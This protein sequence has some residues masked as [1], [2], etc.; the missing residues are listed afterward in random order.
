MTL[1]LRLRKIENKMGILGAN[2]IGCILRFI[3]P[4]DDTNNG[5]PAIAHILTG[6][7]AGKQINRTKNETANQFQ[8]QINVSLEERPGTQET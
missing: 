3:V 5:Q 1:N 2:P 7:N 8:A 4:P 6:P